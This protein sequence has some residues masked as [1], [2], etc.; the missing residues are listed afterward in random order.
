[1]NYGLV[2]IK[3]GVL[4][5]NAVAKALGNGA[6]NN[7][8]LLM[9]ETAAVETQFGLYRDTTPDGAGRGVTQVDKDTFYWIKEL[10]LE[11]APGAC[12]RPKRN[13]RE[14]IISEF[15]IDL[16]RVE[17]ADLDYNPL[18]S[19]I[20]TRLRYL[21]ISERIPVTVEGRAQYW[22]KWYNSTLGKGT[23]EHYIESIEK[24]PE[25]TL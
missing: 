24:L 10:A 3:H 7:A 8:N 20:F 22:K 18:L 16:K 9:I 4:L 1:M 5:A 11:L 6:N 2:S 25:I 13:W 21:V 17:H 14:K 19:F 12:M 15:G 23:P